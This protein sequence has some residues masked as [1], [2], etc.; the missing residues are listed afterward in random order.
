[1]FRQGPLQLMQLAIDCKAEQNLL[2]NIYNYKDFM[3]FM[4]QIFLPEEMIGHF[5]LY[6]ITCLA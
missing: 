1:M 6:K 5:L 4:L 3:N 2:R